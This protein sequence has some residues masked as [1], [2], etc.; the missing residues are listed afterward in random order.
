[1]EVGI[2]GPC[3]RVEYRIGD[4]QRVG[5][6]RIG[7]GD[8]AGLGWVDLSAALEPHDMPSIY[9]TISNKTPHHVLRTRAM[10]AWS[11]EST[12]AIQSLTPTTVLSVFQ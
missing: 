11:R 8:E 6:V 9:N 10:L 12:C 1:M 2:G 7:E 4:G 5:V 3:R